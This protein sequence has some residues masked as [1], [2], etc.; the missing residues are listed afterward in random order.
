ML[1]DR[2]IERVHVHVN[3]IAQ[4]VDV[5][6][7]EVRIAGSL[8]RPMLRPSNRNSRRCLGTVCGKPHFQT[9]MS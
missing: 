3:D 8:P 1:L 4:R 2:R 9:A 5:G 7:Y 6:E